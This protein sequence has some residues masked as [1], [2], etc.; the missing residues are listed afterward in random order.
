MGEMSIASVKM[1]EIVFFASAYRLECM[2]AGADIPQSAERKAKSADNEILVIALSKCGR[3][4]VVVRHWKG[5]FVT[6][7]GAAA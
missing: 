3:L 4:P 7:Q 6:H 2:F 5:W 1:D